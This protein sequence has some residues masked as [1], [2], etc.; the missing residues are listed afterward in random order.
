MD[1]EDFTTDFHGIGHGFSQDCVYLCFVCD[2]LCFVVVDKQ[3]TISLSEVARGYRLRGWNVVMNNNP[4]CCGDSASGIVVFWLE[5]IVGW[6]LFHAEV[7][8]GARSWSSG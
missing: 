7:F 4:G 2:N 3:V 1:D 5:L 8:E 6:G